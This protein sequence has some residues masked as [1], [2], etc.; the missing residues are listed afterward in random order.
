[1]YEL[2]CIVR[3]SVELGFTALVIRPCIWTQLNFFNLKSQ[4]N[5][6]FSKDN[7]YTLRVTQNNPPAERQI[8]YC[9]AEIIF[10]GI[11]DR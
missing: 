8:L 2:K 10:H 1:M 3:D 11:I 6:I 9:L 5:K 4:G 7:P